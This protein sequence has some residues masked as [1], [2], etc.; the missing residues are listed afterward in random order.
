MEALQKP[1]ESFSCNLHSNI[2]SRNAMKTMG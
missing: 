1:T 2:L